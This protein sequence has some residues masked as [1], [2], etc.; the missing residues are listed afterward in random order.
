MPLQFTDLDFKVD[1]PDIP[2]TAP[3]VS[4]TPPCLKEHSESTRAIAEALDIDLKGTAQV[5]HGYAVGSD[6]GQVEVFA[7]SGAVRARNTERL[8]A[9]DDE[10]RKWRDVERSDD[11]T[12]RLG[13]EQAKNLLIQ[14]QQL[15]R[16]VGLLQEHASIDVSLGQWAQLNEDG[17][18]VDSGPGRATVR[19]AYAVDGL[20]LIGPGAKTNLHFDPEDDGRGVSLARMFHVN[21]GVETTGE[22]ATQ[23]LDEAFSGLLA[24]SWSGHGLREGEGRITITAATFGLLALPADVVQ[25]FAA[26][27]LMVEGEVSGVEVGR[28]E[29]VAVRF[30]EYL[31]LAHPKAL[32]EAGYGGGRLEPGVVV[33]GRA[34]G[35]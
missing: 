12:Y 6:R 19:F 30:G 8:T 17:K 34:K 29:T 16:R 14:G 28:D 3:V 20:A 9:Y 32:A 26:P 22:V 11:G 13:D 25:T 21:R 1:L 18:E 7:A 10:R 15:L 27:A 4:H 35:K 31:S 23:S 24:Q 2:R 33:R 5:P